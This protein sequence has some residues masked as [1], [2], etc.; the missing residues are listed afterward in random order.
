M[1][2]ARNLPILTYGDLRGGARIATRFGETGKT[3][4]G[5]G[6]ELDGEDECEDRS[7]QHFE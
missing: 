6:Y 2:P 3:L 7:F 1:T 5:Y 4:A